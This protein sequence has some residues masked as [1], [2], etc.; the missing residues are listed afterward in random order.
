MNNIFQRI[1]KRQARVYFL[2]LYFSFLGNYV[3][4]A[5][6]FTTPQIG[7]EGVSSK[8]SRSNH[9]F[10]AQRVDG[11]YLLYLNKLILGAE[12]KGG[13]YLSPA[14][15]PN[16]AIKVK[17]VHA[18]GH[19][20]SIELLDALLAFL[21]GRGFSSDQIMIV[22]RDHKSLIRAGF[23]STGKKN[24]FYG[25]Y[26]TYSSSSSIYFDPEWFH[27]SPM[28]P[29]AHDRSR[30]FLDFPKERKKRMEE[31]RKSYLPGI[32][33]LK[34]VFWINLSVATDHMNL[35]IDGA[36]SNITTGAIS[37]YQRFLDKP[38][39]GPAAVTEILAIPEI[40]EK[41]IYSILDLSQY[42]FANGGQFDAEFL[43][44]HPTL[45]LSEN[46]I[47]IDFTA[48]S[49]LKDI[50]RKNGFIERDETQ[51]LLFKYAKELGLGEMN[52]V[53]VFDVF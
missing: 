24:C 53:R 26:R 17:T 19:Q 52:K 8:D 51:L 37:N 16:I 46:P 21:S 23:Y 48:L 3:W 29:T 44:S 32:L 45:L 49:V 27:D 30:F 12:K 42:Q 41:R 28:P 13:P 25:K 47:S 20:V 2:I 43:A 36:S 22:D 9:V 1:V 15:F 38:T 6:P 50:R 5:E 14:Q 10:R 31:E 35:G 4:G 11:K 40:W 39:L 33:F 7:N 34:D 18:P